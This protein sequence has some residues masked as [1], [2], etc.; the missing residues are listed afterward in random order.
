MK[1]I[2][3]LFFMNMFSGMGYSIVAPLFP[4]LGEKYNI[5]ESLLGWIISTYAISNSIIT[6]FIPS[7]CKIFTR[8]KLLYFATFFEATC[9]FLY[10]FLQNIS[11]YYTLLYFS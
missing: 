8:I 5:S 11:S 4:T 7:L 1:A 10:G 3:L 9:T 2:T 6:P